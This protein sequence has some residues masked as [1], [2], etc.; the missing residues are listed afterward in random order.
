MLE[1]GDFSE[2]RAFGVGGDLLQDS[3]RRI[4]GFL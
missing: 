2:A 3:D 4:K 1:S